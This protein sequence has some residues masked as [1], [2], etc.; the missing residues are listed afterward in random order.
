MSYNVSGAQ[1]VMLLFWTTCN[2]L[3]P[4]ELQAILCTWHRHVSDQ[5]A[6]QVRRRTTISTV[7]GKA[8]IKCWTWRTTQHMTSKL[9]MCDLPYTF[10]VHCMWYI[11]THRLSAFAICHTCDQTQQFAQYMLHCL[12][13]ICHI[14][15]VMHP[16]K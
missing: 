6:L 10:H 5:Q 2:S 14:L 16:A 4:V 1:T 7:S 13:Y 15:H 11:S 8:Y 9:R 3:T 12:W